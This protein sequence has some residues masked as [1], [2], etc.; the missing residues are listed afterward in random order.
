M[1]DIIRQAA[2]RQKDGHIDEYDY[3]ESAGAWSP[4]SKRFA[5][6]GV[7][8]GDNV[9]IIKEVLTGKTVDEFFMEGVPAF[10][11]P[12]WSPDGKTIVVSGLVNGQTDLYLLNLRTKK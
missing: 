1:G 12:A 3:V 10:Q 4:D 7:R 9:L 11:N 2:V 6:S 8:N 5:F